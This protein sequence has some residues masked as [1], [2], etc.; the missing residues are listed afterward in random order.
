MPAWKPAGRRDSLAC[1][2]PPGR[3][4]QV[5]DPERRYLNSWFKTITSIAHHEP[6]LI[7]TLERE[8]RPERT[9]GEGPFWVVS[10]PSLKPW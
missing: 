4:R 10:R 2:T 5:H 8:T 1:E 7:A 9:L 3:R 6:P